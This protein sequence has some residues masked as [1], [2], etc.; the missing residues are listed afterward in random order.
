MVFDK[1]ETA[2][3]RRM[4]ALAA[5]DDTV[6]MA[7]VFDVPCREATAEQAAK[8]AK[9]AFTTRGLYAAMP[10]PEAR[11]A[12]LAAEPVL[13]DFAKTHPQTFLQITARENG[14]RAYEAFE[15]LARFRQQVEAQGVSEGEAQAQASRFLMGFCARPLRPGDPSPVE[16]PQDYTS[17]ENGLN[18]PENQLEA[19]A[20]VAAGVSRDVR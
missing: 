1:I 7:P 11:L 16:P 14:A 18:A 15:R 20:A 4:Q 19:P 6:V 12:C 3:A 9:L 10:D 8:L 2:Q 5:Q 17:E 13:A